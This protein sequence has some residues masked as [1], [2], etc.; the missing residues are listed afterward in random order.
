VEEEIIPFRMTFR[1][2]PIQRGEHTITFLY[3]P[4]SMIFGGAVSLLMLLLLVGVV[5]RFPR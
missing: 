5:I 4:K 3:R 1:S 2:V